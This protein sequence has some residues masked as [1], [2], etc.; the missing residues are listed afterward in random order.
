MR[1]E[2]PWSPPSAIATSPAAIRAALPPDEPPAEW[3][4]LCGLRIGPVTQV[5]LPAEKQRSSQ[6][7]LP[8][9]VPPASRIRVTTVA[10]SSG[11]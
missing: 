3:S 1:I 5:W 11:T 10:S 6:A 7:A 4:G 8:A 9:M 2:P